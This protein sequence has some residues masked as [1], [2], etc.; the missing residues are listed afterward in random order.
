MTVPAWLNDSVRD[1]GRQMGLERF[2]LS[3]RGTAGVRFENGV[4]LRLEYVEDRG[5]FL[6][7]SVPLAAAG[8]PGLRR[9]FASVHPDANR[10]R[11]VVHAAVLSHSD[12]A[13]AAVCIPAR[14]VDVPAL[15]EAMALAWQRVAGETG[16]AA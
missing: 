16:G 15:Q 7:A 14:E 8:A 1:F 5:L 11:F 9:L 10:G 6:T 3:E 12:E 2:G 13:A 4:A